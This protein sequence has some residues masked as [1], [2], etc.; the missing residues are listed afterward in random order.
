[1]APQPR[2]PDL[3]QVLTAP[4]VSSTGRTQVSTKVTKEAINLAFD[5]PLSS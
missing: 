3:A 5:T 2:V 1:M 4:L